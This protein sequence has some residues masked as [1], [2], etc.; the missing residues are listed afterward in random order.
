MTLFCLIS[1]NTSKIFFSYHGIIPQPGSYIHSA[2]WNQSFDPEMKK[3][4]IKR[5]MFQPEMKALGLSNPCWACFPWAVLPHLPP[6][7]AELFP[8][9][10]Q[11]VLTAPVMHKVLKLL[12]SRGSGTR[13]FPAWSFAELLFTQRVENKGEKK[14]KHLHK[15]LWQTLWCA[16]KILLQQ[17]TCQPSCWGHTKPV[18]Q[19]HFNS[20][21]QV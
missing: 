1:T 2:L 5:K 18:I 4:I 10:P 9:K 14:W 7:H 17:G 8:F 3:K 21:H 19:C 13:S 6:P 12:H 16:T 15:V 20:L 11:C